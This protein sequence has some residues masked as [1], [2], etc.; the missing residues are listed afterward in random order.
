M[1]TYIIGALVGGII[2]YITNWLAIKMLFR[3]YGEKRIFGIKIPFTPGLIP[4]EKDR[5]AKSVGKTIG[6]HLLTSDTIVKSLDNEKIKNEINKKV[7]NKVNMI[8]SEERT[9]HK[10]FQKIFG[11]SSKVYEDKLRD[12]IKKDILVSIKSQKFIDMISDAISTN[13]ILE[14]KSSPEILKRFIKDNKFKTLILRLINNIKKSEDFS[15]S[16]EESLI[17]KGKKAIENNKK[18]SDILPEQ[19]IDIVE[20]IIYKKKDFI[21][22]EFLKIFTSE[23]ISYKLKNIIGN[24]IPSIVSMFMSI[25]SIYDKIIHIIEGCLSKEKNKEYICKLIIYFIN[26][27]KN[28]LIEDITNNISKDEIKDISLGLTEYINENI[29][30]E[31]SINIYINKIEN[32]ILSLESYEEVIKGLDENY[33]IN[34]KNFIKDRVEGLIKNENTDLVIEKAANEYIDTLMNTQLS[35]IL[36]GEKVISEK[37]FNLIEKYYNNFINEDA[38]KF[39]KA[40]D[41]PSLVEN[42]IRSFEVSYTEEIILDIANKELKAITW[43][44]AALG[45]ILGLISP[46]LSRLYI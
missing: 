22:D 4:K 10:T 5:I 8:L 36:P 44:G 28:I 7:L 12:R 33:E 6:E 35:D 41:I 40:M 15:R 17:I 3:P 37:V 14:L 46:L 19:F 13:I 27:S 2:G 26:N 16:I 30:T 32:Y 18:L 43:L 1:R 11:E 23:E 39:I 34:T 21:S 38:G 25:D 31:D 45:F 42:Q 24:N 20:D 29:L 9:I